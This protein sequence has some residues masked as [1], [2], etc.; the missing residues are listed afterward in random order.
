MTLPLCEF[1]RRGLTSTVQGFAF[2]GNALLAFQ[3]S[4]AGLKVVEGYVQTLGSI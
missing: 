1:S 2:R 3:V 4:G